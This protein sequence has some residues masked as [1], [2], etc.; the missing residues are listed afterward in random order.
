MRE[1]RFHCVGISSQRL[2][3][4]APNEVKRRGDWPMHALCGL[5]TELCAT[6]GMTVRVR[7]I[8]NARA[9]LEKGLHDVVLFAELTRVC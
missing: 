9:A 5:A 7:V 8:L 4:R 6:T 1:I 2:T 3:D